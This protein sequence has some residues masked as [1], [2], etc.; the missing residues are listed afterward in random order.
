MSLSTAL[1]VAQSALR[2]TSR[3]TSI[4]SRNISEASNPDYNRRTAVLVSSAR[5]AE[6][7]QIGRAANEVLFRQN[8]EALSAY[9][10]QQALY[11]GMATLALRRQRRR[12]RQFGRHRTGE[13]PAGA[14]ALFGLALQPLDRRKRRRGRAAARPHAEPGQPGDPGL[15]HRHRPPDRERGRFAQF[16]ARRSSRTPTTRS[17]TAP[18]SA[19]TSTTRSTS[20]TRF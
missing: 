19:A 1:S 20:A 2:N 11:D 16:A 7:S 12:Q 3:Q 14:A 15:P 13:L 18:G 9:Q 17:S 4:V 6:I 10:G 5:G 8:L